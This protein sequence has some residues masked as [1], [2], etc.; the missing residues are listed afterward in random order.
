MTSL[1]YGLICFSVL[2]FGCS[3]QPTV[4]VYAKYLDNQ[5]REDV[6]RTFEQSGKY[7]V[8]L[9][10]FDFPTSV[11]T[12][13]LLYS[14]LL[15]DPDTIDAAADLSASAGFPIQ[16]TQG[17]TQGNNWYTKNSMA[18]FLLPAHL[19]S[20]APFFVQ[21]LVHDYLA[22]NCDVAQ[23]LTLAKDGTFS[24]QFATPNHGA[25]K[26]SVHGTWKYRQ[27]PFV[28]LQSRDSPY[29]DF[30]F[31]IEQFRGAD[32]VSEIDYLKL[33]LL[34]GSLPEGCAFLIGTRI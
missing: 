24:L 2:F 19:G 3:S 11:T 10:E 16:R 14:L 9:N 29:A 30:Y 28:E 32:K 12:N 31:E 17:L 15:R 8:E 5:Q 20:Q 26:E 6:T 27:Y 21:D 18:L 23:S 25:T 34:N 33:Q 7:Q 1:K 22:D 13:T 4:F